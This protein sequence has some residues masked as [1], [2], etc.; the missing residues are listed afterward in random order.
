MRTYNTAPI[1]LLR[2]AIEYDRAT[3][4]LTWK[5]RPRSHFHND[6]TWCRFNSVYAGKPAL[7][8]VN[9]RGYKT[10]AFMSVRLLAHRVAWAL[11]KDAWPDAEIDHIN[12]DRADNRWDNLR[13]VSAQ[14]NM[15]N[16]PLRVTTTSGH[17]GISWHKQRR[18][19]QANIGAGREYFYLGVF[20][21]IN[22]A[23][24]ARKAAEVKYGF[25]P[26]HGRSRD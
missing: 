22:D 25:H 10:G 4:D 15:K 16:T 6:K 26:N 24:A 11:E 3:G 8:S 17:V 2:E 23:I 5:H 1:Y 21:D 12:G 19:W 9:C 7:A 18:K 20:A 13:N 14:T